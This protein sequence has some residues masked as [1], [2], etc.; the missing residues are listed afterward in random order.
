[1]KDKR[2]RKKRELGFDSS[3]VGENEVLK[4]N[5]QINK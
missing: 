4:Q 5:L 1:M 2:R 3:I